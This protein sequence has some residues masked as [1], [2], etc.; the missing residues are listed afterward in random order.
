MD[1]RVISN[2]KDVIIEAGQIS[3]DLRD[4]GLI[5]EHKKDSSP[6]TNA[7]IAVSNFIYSKLTALD[8]K[9]PIICEEQPLKDVSTNNTIWLVDPIDG[10]KSYLKNMDSFTINIAL[11]HNHIPVIGLIYQPTSKKLYFTTHEKK[12]RIEKNGT[13]IKALKKY[14]SN[15]T[16]V[17]SSRNFNLKTEQYLQNF[18]FSEVISIPSSIK[19]CMVAEG[20]VDVYPKF[21]PTMEWDVAA[22]HA[23]ILASGGNVINSTTG[24]PLLYSK[25]NFQNPDFIA[26]GKR[27]LNFLSPFNL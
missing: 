4:K 11:V 24:K 16:A 5:I 21:G 19:L 20:S 10:T 1:Q 13:L 26:S 18:G 27:Y 22:G 8:Q 23:L 7:D 3:I 15:Y 9:I 14:D 2:L 6:V 17:V 12:L 25:S